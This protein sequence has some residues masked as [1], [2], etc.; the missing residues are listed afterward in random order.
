[1]VTQTFGIS[2]HPGE[3]ATRETR[4]DGQILRHRLDVLAA[5]TGDVV[6]TT[7]GWLFDRVMAGWEVNVLL[8]HGCPARPLRVLGVQVLHLES[9]L[10]GA[11]PMSQSLAV[12]VEAFTAH[13]CVREL[14]RKAV[15]NRLTEVALWGEG[16]PLGVN[17]GLTRTQY[18]L[19]AAARA[20]KGQALRAA[21]IPYLSIDHTETLFTDSA[22]LG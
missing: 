16:W 18:R 1:M 5:D 6:Q 13:D 7:G 22:W 2:G 11:G 19:S 14:V 15:D 8:P 21:G 3:G 17:R 20:F 12:S 4:A 10:R 9:E